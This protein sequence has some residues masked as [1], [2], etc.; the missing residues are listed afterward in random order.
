MCSGLKHLHFY[1]LWGPNPNTS[2]YSMYGMYGDYWPIQFA[3]LK[4]RGQMCTVNIPYPLSIWEIISKPHRW[5]CMG[6]SIVGKHPCF[7]HGVSY[8]CSSYFQPIWAIYYKSFT[9]IKGIL[10]EFPCFSPPFSGDQTGGLVVRNL[11]RPMDLRSSVVGGDI[12]SR[13]YKLG[14]VFNYCPWKKS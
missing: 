14:F 13:G 5:Q 11:P 3:C 9:W 12:K 4:F 6:H 8:V 1:W 2:K 7:Q 10:G